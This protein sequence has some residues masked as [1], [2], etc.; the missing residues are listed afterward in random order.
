MSVNK[1]G[2]G[3]FPL[4]PGRP[5]V[6]RCRRRG[7]WGFICDC[8]DQASTGQFGTEHPNRDD[9]VDALRK[10][11]DHIRY[12]HKTAAELETERLE[13]MFAADAFTGS[14]S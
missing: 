12:W 11:Q 10:A 1:P 14:G 2:T 3:R 7:V 5:F 6:F 9:W 13:R 8:L 4:H